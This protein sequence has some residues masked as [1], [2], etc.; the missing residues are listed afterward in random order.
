MRISIRLNSQPGPERSGVGQG[1]SDGA[2]EIGFFM[3]RRREIAIRR[4]GSNF[5]KPDIGGVV[6]L[7]APIADSAAP[8]RRRNC[9][10]SR[11]R[12]AADG[13]T[14]GR[15]HRRRSGAFS[16]RRR[17]DPAHWQMVRFLVGRRP[18]D[19]CGPAPNRQPQLHCG[20]DLRGQGQGGSDHRPGTRLRESLH[21]AARG[22]RLLRSG[23]DHASGG[24]G[25]P[26][27]TGWRA[28]S[29]S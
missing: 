21:W 24:R 15:L 8:E 17:L 7:D 29:T 27:Y 22:Q 5:R 25:R 16:R 19:P 14:S 10:V 11:G 4:R 9:H 1:S 18:A 23:V 20:V 2:R 13:R 28:S 6:G 3:L 12:R 26:L